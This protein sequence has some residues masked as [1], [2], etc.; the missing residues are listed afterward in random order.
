MSERIA[1][2]FPE[3]E[4]WSDAQE[5]SRSAGDADSQ[6][7][8][9]QGRGPGLHSGS[10]SDSVLDLQEQVQQRLAESEAA[11][12][13]GRDA[14]ESSGHNQYLGHRFIFNTPSSYAFI[15]LRHSK[16]KAASLGS[17]VHCPAC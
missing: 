7:H 11:S 13:S 8:H 6:R 15:I 17:S 3:A 14:S 16:A 2:P 10:T 12:T 1:E 9:E 5:S 4:Y